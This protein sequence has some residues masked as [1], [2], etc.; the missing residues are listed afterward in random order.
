M[1]RS[2]KTPV[3]PN[4]TLLNGIREA[5]PRILFCGADRTVDALRD[6]ALAGALAREF[7]AGSIVLTS[8]S[9][10]LLHVPVRARIQV[11]RVP[12]F[13]RVDPALALLR[14]RVRRLRRRMFAS[15][16]DAYL[17]DLVL[18][19]L[20]GPEARLE[21]SDLLVRVQALESSHLLVENPHP[22]GENCPYGRRS[23]TVG[24]CPA[25][26]HRI[27]A[28]TRHS[29]ERLRGRRPEREA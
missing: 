21:I 19:D 16:F 5:R 26:S 6:L 10:E 15:L 7:E 22:E 11:A 2:G 27:R 20:A 8:G 18:F 25:C 4:L 3:R 13:E 17:P 12:S 28:A 14:E 9:F 29:Y 23:A 24:A 1:Q